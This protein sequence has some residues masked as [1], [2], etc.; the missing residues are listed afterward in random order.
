MDHRRSRPPLILSLKDHTPF[1][2]E[3]WF[4]KRLRVGREVGMQ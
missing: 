3:S 2:E 1:M 4:G